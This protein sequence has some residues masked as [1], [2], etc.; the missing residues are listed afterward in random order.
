MCVNSWLWP[1]SQNWSCSLSNRG[2]W[3]SSLL[4]IWQSGALWKIRLMNEMRFRFYNRWAGWRQSRKCVENCCQDGLWQENMTC[5]NGKLSQGLLDHREARHRL[6]SWL[7]I[8]SRTTTASADSP[9]KV[10]PQ[11]S[12]YNDKRNHPDFH[13]IATISAAETWIRQQRRPA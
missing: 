4:Q 3:K 13:R 7:E 1:A 12:F 6:R 2:N 8:S 5:C 10:T 11:S 9:D